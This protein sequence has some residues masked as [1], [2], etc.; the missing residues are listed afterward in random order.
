MCS[1]VLI[2]LK[3]RHARMREGSMLFDKHGEPMFT[4]A[5]AVGLACRNLDQE[6]AAGRVG[7]I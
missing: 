5:L 3:K 1:V 2:G 4:G 6:R 7:A